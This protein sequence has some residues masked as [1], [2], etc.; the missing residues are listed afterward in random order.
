MV[1]QP[2]KNGERYMEQVSP[3]DHHEALEA[4]IRECFG[5]VVYATKTHEKCADRLMAKM[6]M[7]KFWQITISALTTGGLIT[8]ILSSPETRDIATVIAAGLST[9]LLALNSYTKGSDPG[10]LAE[11]H[12]EVAS[13]LWDIRESYLSLLTDLNDK[14]I[15]AELARKRRDE[16]Q[17]SLLAIYETAP[18]TN[19]KAYQAASDGLKNREELTFSQSEINAF[20]P[21]PLKR[22]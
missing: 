9:I 3:A 18:R 6:G 14:Q 20:V 13:K 7:I 22:P 16:L 11:K 2:D 5:R 19:A 10:Q 8:A 1:G 17:K 4:Q 12:K 21:D 15:D